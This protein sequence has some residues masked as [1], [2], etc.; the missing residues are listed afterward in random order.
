MLRVWRFPSDHLAVFDSPH[1]PD[2]S[3][4]TVNISPLVSGINAF[5]CNNQTAHKKSPTSPQKQVRRGTLPPNPNN[6]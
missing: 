2:E 3:A 6:V 4:V 5:F 1:I